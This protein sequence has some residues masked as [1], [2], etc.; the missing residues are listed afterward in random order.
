MTCSRRELAGAGSLGMSMSVMGGGKNREYRKDREC[1]EYREYRKC[2]NCSRPCI[3]ELRNPVAARTASKFLRHSRLLASRYSRHSRPLRNPPAFVHLPVA[4]IG[5][6]GL[7]GDVG[8]F[9]PGKRGNVEA[10]A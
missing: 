8:N 1:R 10:E 4:E 6:H 3:G 9:N 2:R 5:R 7:R